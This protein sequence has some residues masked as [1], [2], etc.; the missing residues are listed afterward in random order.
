M[1]EF[2]AEFIKISKLFGRQT[3]AVSLETR[4]LRTGELVEDNFELTLI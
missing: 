2:R 4:K 3:S 1:Y